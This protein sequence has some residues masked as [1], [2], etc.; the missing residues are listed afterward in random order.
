MHLNMCF[1][2]DSDFEV[3][4]FESGRLFVGDVVKCDVIARAVI[5]VRRDWFTSP[6][7]RRMSIV[8]GVH[9][10]SAGYQVATGSSV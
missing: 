3:P 1:S 9:K 5:K 2:F 4:F 10:G 8:V 6:M 7:S